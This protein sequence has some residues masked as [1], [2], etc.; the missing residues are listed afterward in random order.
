MKLSA[1]SQYDA[2][3]LLKKETHHHH[4]LDSHAAMFTLLIVGLGV[5]TA[6]VISAIYGSMPFTSSVTIPTIDRGF[7]SPDRGPL[8]LSS[9]ETSSTVPIPKEYQPYIDLGSVKGYVMNSKGLPV[10]GA[11]VAIYKHMALPGSADKNAGY[12]T[13]I[14]TQSD[15]SYSFNSLPSGVYKFTV[16]YPDAVIQTIDNYAVSPSSS[17]TYTFRK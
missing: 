13:S 10:D 3:M 1:K 6:I 8:S 9:E 4:D 15:G 14:R 17:S 16:T 12:S 2:N 5:I 7:T 11:L